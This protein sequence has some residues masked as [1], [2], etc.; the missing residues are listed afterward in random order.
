MAGFKLDLNARAP[1]DVQPHQLNR[2]DAR[3]LA[4]RLARGVPFARLIECRIGNSGDLVVMEVDVETPQRP[5]YDIRLVER[6]AVWFERSNA[7]GDLEPPEALALREDFPIDAP[8]LNLRW[9]EY[10]KSLCLFDVPF[11]ELRASW[12][13]SRFI[14]LIREWLRLTARGSLH[15]ADQPLEPLITGFGWLI[16]PNILRTQDTVALGLSR[17]GQ[18]RGAPVFVAVPVGDLEKDDP[19]YV[20]GIIR[21][22]ARTHGV[23]RRAPS[24]VEDL[25]ELLQDQDDV[26]AALIALLRRW[27]ADDVALDVP[28]ALVLLV[29]IRRN[30]QG[31]A[32]V[33]QPWAFFTKKTAAE[34]GESLGLWVRTPNGLGAVIGGPA[35]DGGESIEL[36]TINALF[37][38]RR[39]D[40]AMYNDRAPD[41]RRLVAVGAGSL[42][43]QVLD[44]FGRTS[45]GRWTIIDADVLLPHNLA[46][47]EAED[48]AVGWEKARWASVAMAGAAEDGEVHGWL[49]TNVLS[50]K[51]QRAAVDAAYD[52]ATAIVDLSASIPVAR[53]LALDTKSNGRRMSL[54]VNPTGTDLVL[55]AEPLDRSVGLDA[56][57]M[58]YYRAVA[59]NEELS[60]TLEGSVAR[61]RYG[62][63]CRDVSSRLQHPKMKTLAGIGAHAIQRLI[64][65]PS[66]QIR[67]WR[68]DD[69]TMAVK[70]VTVPVHS[71]IRAPVGDWCLVADD[72]LV[73]RLKALRAAKLPNETG[74]V[75]LGTIDVSRKLVYVVDTIPSPPDSKEWPTLY[76]RGAEGLSDKV[77]RVHE[78]TGGQL[79]YVGEWHSH[80]AGCPPYPSDDDL[81]VF[82]WITEALDS[83]D[84]PA[85]M[86]IV[87]DEGISMFIGSIAKG[88]PAAVLQLHVEPAL[89]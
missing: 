54:F 86:L 64:D 76:I 6:I 31:D 30:D 45:F 88:V 10:P 59:T 27:K 70:A 89:A 81:K 17:R 78:Q 58:Q 22:S 42:G 60:G 49:G 67:V 38:N 55:L 40:A 79:H 66:G 73:E 9:H 87:G 21:A 36:T 8:H 5:V 20:V 82:A 53:S 61:E 85:V 56:L 2:I 69:E 35:G 84:L 33:E 1:I 72:A 50:P 75:L 26:R 62:R 4:E 7:G 19:R 23:I 28:L 25:H 37:Q 74:G 13:P 34:L 80:P 47:H 52:H 3:E 48:S 14:I 16:L 32:E 65:V 83:D 15:A 63:S 41:D 12:T 24:T 57:E 18:T 11:E 29:P 68:S 51:E 71:E 46:R 77:N 39:Q 44:C 43:S